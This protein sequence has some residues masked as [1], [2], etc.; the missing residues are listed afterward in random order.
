M[1]IGIPARIIELLDAECYLAIA[2]LNGEKRSISIA[3]LVDDEHPAESCV[4]EWVLV[5]VGFA[6]SR[7][8]EAEALQRLALLNELG[9]IQSTL[10]TS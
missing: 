5:H 3:A 8:D 10:G 7:L 4:G 6:V 9:T 2:E 1:C